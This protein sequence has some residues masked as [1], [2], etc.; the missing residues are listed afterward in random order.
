MR[1]SI[2]DEN[3][4]GFYVAVQKVCFVQCDDTLA[5]LHEVSAQVQE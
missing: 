1:S 4:G 5:K 2:G 3:I